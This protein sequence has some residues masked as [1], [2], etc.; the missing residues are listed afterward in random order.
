MPN[1]VNKASKRQEDNMEKI[2]FEPIWK[3]HIVGEEAEYL[4]TVP[5]KMEPGNRQ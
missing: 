5:E 1:K 2:K 3:M 4:A